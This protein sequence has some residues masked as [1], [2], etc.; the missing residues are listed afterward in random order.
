[1]NVTGFRE[2]AWIM[3]LVVIVWIVSSFFVMFLLNKLDAI[4][5]GELYDYGLQF[6]FAWATPF[7]SFERLIYICLAVPSILGGIVLVL[8]FLKRG[9]IE[10]PVAKPVE[11]K[12]TSGRVRSVKGNSMLISCPK[13]KKVFGKP[14]TMLDFSDGKTRLVNVCPYCNHIL[15]DA[16][17][18]DSDNI[19]VADLIGEEVKEK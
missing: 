1:M 19:R 13:C 9:K 10:T 7:W 16:D 15:G 6:S 8:D 3:R 5:H 18:T 14:L 11:K 17:E 12:S 4:V 2:S